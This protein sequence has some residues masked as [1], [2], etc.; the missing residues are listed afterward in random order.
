[1]LQEIHFFSLLMGRSSLK[2]G[3]GMVSVSDDPFQAL[4][5]AETPFPYF[6][7]RFSRGFVFG[8]PP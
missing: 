5:L 8:K 2:L 6:L 3:I 1:M 7:L 4:V